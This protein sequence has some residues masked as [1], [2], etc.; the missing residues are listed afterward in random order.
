MHVHA[1]THTHTGVCMVYATGR[2]GGHDQFASKARLTQYITNNTVVVGQ[3]GRYSRGCCTEYSVG[4]SKR[5]S[6]G[7]Q[8][9]L[10]GYSTGTQWAL[11]PGVLDAALN[12]VLNWCTARVRKG[13]LT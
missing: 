6:V 7:T 8:W 13:C 5:C 11:T 2:W 12:R 1:R 4:Y 10:S 9:V 3:V